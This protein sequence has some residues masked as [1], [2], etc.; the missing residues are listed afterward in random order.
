MTLAAGDE[1]EYVLAHH[2]K[3]ARSPRGSSGG[4]GGPQ[5]AGAAAWVKRELSE[6]TNVIHYAKGPDGTRGFA[7]GRGRPIAAPP[8]SSG[9]AV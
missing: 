6:R 5:G 2:P 8:A 4:Q 9:D 3:T 7:V 1:V